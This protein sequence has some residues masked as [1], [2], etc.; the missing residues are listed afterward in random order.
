MLNLISDIHLH[1]G[2]KGFAADG[3]PDY[4]DFTIWDYY[5]PQEEALQKL[6]FALRAAVKE[7]AIASQANLDACVEARLHIPFLALYP[8]ERQMFD[9]DPQRPFRRL[10]QFLLRGEQHANLGA[11][12]TGFPIEKIREAI[13][14]VT[15]RQN[16]VCDYYEEY[17]QERAYLLRQSETRSKQYPDYRFTIV[18]NYQ[19]LQVSVAN[20]QTIAG[21]LTVE[22]AHAFGRYPCYTILRKEWEELTPKQ[23]VALRS[24]FL[25]NVLK[26]KTEEDGR[27]APFF[28][29]FCHH[30]NNLLAG[31]A[32]SFS[33]KAPLALG[34]NKPG[35]RHL[36]NQEP[37]LNRGFTPLG[38]E[39]LDLMLD[40]KQ[41]RRILIDTK[42]MSVATRKEFYTYIR[43][44]R[45]FEGDQIPI[46]HSHAAISGWAT[47]DQA[48]SQQDN[49][50]LDKGHFFSRWQINLTNEDILETYDSDGLIGVVLHEG[51]MPGADF[52]KQV[53]KLRQRIERYRNDDRRRLYVERELKDLYLKL[54]WS[55]IFHMIK[56]VRDL[57]QED[58]WKMIALGSDYDGLVDPI[59]AFPEVDSF[60]DLRQ[61]MIHYLNAGEEIYF[62]QNGEAKLLPLSEV[63]ALQQGQSAKQ[64][65]D[66]ILGGNTQAFLA[67]YFTESYL[68]EN[69]S[70]MTLA[71]PTTTNLVSR[72]A[73]A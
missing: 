56:V 8:I 69:V 58:G 32:R 48:A 43:N 61:E 21:L 68:T 57:R 33:D 5:P 63:R 24:S 11:A 27:L 42:H 19:D 65:L 40:R 62:L 3:Y 25:E 37:G 72:R 59:N 73:T 20:G 34:L 28:V 2:L 64:L 67:K 31:H 18:T 38:R 45:E 14:Q 7:T 66:R 22:G 36:F 53:R 9:L 50:D 12:V 41:G 70:D 6:N 51:R 16:A 52:H 29:T 10:F 55:T 47:L 15:E 17:L 54:V 39:V 60:Q 13:A 26:V 4:E 1:C 23:V 30:F 44:K 49:N 46:V 71:T 35:M